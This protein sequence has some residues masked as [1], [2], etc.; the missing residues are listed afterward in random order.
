MRG[1][2]STLPIGLTSRKRRLAILEHYF[3]VVVFPEFPKE[4]GRQY[5]ENLNAFF[6]LDNAEAGEKKLNGKREN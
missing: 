3:T 5:A 6:A 1:F 4:M 2:L